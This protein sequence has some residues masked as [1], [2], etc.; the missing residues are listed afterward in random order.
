[1]I[2]V[3]AQAAIGARDLLLA[4]VGSTLPGNTTAVVSEQP[5]AATSRVPSVALISANSRRIVVVLGTLWGR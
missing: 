3:D 1:M 5:Y 4:D 2:D